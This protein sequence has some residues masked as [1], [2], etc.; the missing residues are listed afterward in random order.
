MR[1]LMR[2]MGLSAQEVIQADEVIIRSRDKEIT[3]LSPQVIKIT[4]QGQTLYQVVDGTEKTHEQQPNIK[5]E[6]P[7]TISDDDVNFVAMQ[8]NVPHEVARATLVETKGD[9]AKALIKLKST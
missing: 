2:Q 3:I 9:I 1:R 4:I 5:K 6:E 8:A 7:I